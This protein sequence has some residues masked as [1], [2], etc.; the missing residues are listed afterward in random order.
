MLGDD[1]VADEGNS[2][3][4]FWVYLTLAEG[5]LR[6]SVEK[7]VRVMPLGRAGTQK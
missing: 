2:T 3:D 1:V 7:D 4:K 5:M 6:D